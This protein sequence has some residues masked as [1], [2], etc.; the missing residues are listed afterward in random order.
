MRTIL[1][2]LSGLVFFS[3]FLLNLFAW[4][5]GKI[6][7]SQFISSLASFVLL[8]MLFLP[9]LDYKLYIVSS[10]AI[11]LGVLFFYTKRQ[12]SL[13]SNMS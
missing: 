7:S 5:K 6:P 8:G 12:E 9:P 11:L 2:T 4:I 1:L 10:A 3:F 13:K